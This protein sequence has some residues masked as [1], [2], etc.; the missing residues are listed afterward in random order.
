MLGQ[1]LFEILPNDYFMAFG[2]SRSEQIVL[3]SN[4]IC[5]CIY[6]TE[7]DFACLGSLCEVGHL[8]HG[9]VKP[10][11]P[12]FCPLNIIEIGRAHV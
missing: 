11:I 8:A 5:V 3:Y 12:G 7:R 6:D 10:Y 2:K 4:C 1:K 9:W